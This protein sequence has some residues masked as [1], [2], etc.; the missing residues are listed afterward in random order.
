MVKRDFEDTEHHV[1]EASHSGSSIDIEHPRPPPYTST[2][3]VFVSRHRAAYHH[4]QNHSRTPLSSPLPPYDQL[5]GHHHVPPP[6]K[7]VDAPSTRPT[8]FHYRLPP[9]PPHN[10]SP[11]RTIDDIHR[12]HLAPHH[13]VITTD[14]PTGRQSRR[15][16]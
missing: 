6:S 5:P 14:T 9:V 7:N 13:Q 10:H 8:S 15:T 4:Y 12:H 2:T 16:R 1:F 11:L 3:T